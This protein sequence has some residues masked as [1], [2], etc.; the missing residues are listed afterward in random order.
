MRRLSFARHRRLG[1]AA[2]A[3]GYLDVP[4]SSTLGRLP[5]LFGGWAL[6][7]GRPVTRV[8]L[9]INETIMIPARIGIERPDVRE[10][11]N[12]PSWSVDCGW[13]VTVDLAPWPEGDLHV[14]VVVE[15]GSEERSVLV[16]KGYALADAAPSRDIEDPRERELPAPSWPWDLPEFL[17][18][19]SD[20]VTEVIATVSP[21]ER[22]P[23]DDSYLE[24][25]RSAL[26]AIRLAQ[27]AAGKD[28]FG[29]ILDMPS[30]HGRV[31]RWLRAAYPQARV[32]ACDLL[33]DG[34]DFCA[35]TFGATPV[36][37]SQL[38]TVE[39]FADRYDLIFVGSL[40]THVDVRHWDHL[41]ALWH[42]LLNPDGLLVVTTHGE[43]VAE[44]M[45]AGH[46]YGYPP[47]A[48]TRTL[49]AYE[50]AGFAFL[51]EPPD[52]IDY[53][54]TLARADWTIRRLLQ[55]PDFRVVMYGEALWHRHQ[56]VVAVVNRP[57]RSPSP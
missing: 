53:G 48:V 5:I 19:T 13:A 47:A 6:V 28:D 34:V 11:L 20:Q 32:T 37:S 16:D 7:N 57:L 4:T 9:V 30:G 56:D 36:Y 21:Q 43:L 8:E 10:N 1:G 38:P 17:A 14:Q 41:I 49:R 2:S 52:N 33:T 55:H 40:L 31:L 23:A 42:D 51:E 24:V 12:Q 50:H 35:A 22:M 3:I 18:E 27:L 44:R 29:S 54:I 45:R 15:S 39:A 46:N 26:K 25:G